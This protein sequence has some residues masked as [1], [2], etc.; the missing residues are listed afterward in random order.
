MNK[1]VSFRKYS[2]IPIITTLMN[3]FVPAAFAEESLTGEEVYNQTCV[4]CH[5][6]GMANAP[7]AHNE[8]QW[9]DKLDKGMD[10][11]MKNALG[12]I[13]A[14][15]A[16]GLCMACTDDEIKSAIKFMSKPATKNLGLAK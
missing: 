11:L 13:N 10:L 12:G 4:M 2:L 3:H 5:S 15:P 9:A 14:M 8:G 16:R 1:K 6:S 7:I